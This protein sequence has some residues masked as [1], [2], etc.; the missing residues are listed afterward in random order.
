[1]SSLLTRL[2]GRGKQCKDC[3]QILLL[4]LL[5]A[6]GHLESPHQWKSSFRV[7]TALSYLVLPRLTSP[8]SPSALP[9][10]APPPL[11]IP[12]SAH[13]D[14]SSWQLSMDSSGSSSS[15]TSSTS[16]SS[17]CQNPLDTKCSPHPDLHA[18]VCVSHDSDGDGAV[19][20]SRLTTV[21]GGKKAAVVAGGGPVSSPSSPS[22]TSSSPRLLSSASGSCGSAAGAEEGGGKD[23]PCGGQRC[24]AG[25][26][27]CAGSGKAAVDG[28]AV[29]PAGADSLTSAADDDDSCG[30]GAAA[31]SAN[32][33]ALSRLA[34]EQWSKVRSSTVRGWSLFCVLCD[35]AQKS[36]ETKILHLVAIAGCAAVVG[37]GFGAWGYRRWSLGEGR[38]GLRYD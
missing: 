16:S 6:I 22:R 3:S 30:G 20:I 28:A 31:A 35:C 32:F 13:S 5:L 38:K 10:S 21:G 14:D 19:L 17:S 11:S 12:A 4:F 24:L 36:R 33:V 9:H 18:S 26:L 8:L 15:T 7:P 37:A 23:C 1:M 2:L 25:C 34:S 27:R 29:P